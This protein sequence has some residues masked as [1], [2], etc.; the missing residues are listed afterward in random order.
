MLQITI[1]EKEYWNEITEEF[2]KVK[3][4]TLTLEHSLVSVEKWEM[5]YH[6]S[7]LWTFGKKPT[8]DEIRDYVKFMTLTQNVDPNVY[9]SLTR[10]NFK[11]IFDYINDS[12]TATTFRETKVGK[13]NREY[14]TSELIY[15]WMIKANIP[16]E[17]RK[18]HLNHLLTLIRVY[19]E[20]E[21]PRKK[22]SSMETMLDYKALNEQRKKEWNT[23][24]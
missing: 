24:G 14:I 20:K 11:Q 10:E 13:Q 3:G 15:Y 4:Q 12:M 7:F 6:K 23:T 2:I 5:K 21:K 16:F 8:E 1:P 9:M 18:W 17:C 22:R 19:N